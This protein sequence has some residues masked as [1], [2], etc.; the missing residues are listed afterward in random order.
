MKIKYNLNVF[1]SCKNDKNMQHDKM[2]VSFV[3]RIWRN[4]NK[5]GMDN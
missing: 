1:L 4:L 5:V 3:T 2:S